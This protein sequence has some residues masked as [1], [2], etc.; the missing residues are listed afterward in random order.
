MYLNK[1]PVKL[2]KKFKPVNSSHIS[3]KRI[4][5][6]LLPV[7]LAV[8]IFSLTVGKEIYG[9]RELTLLSFAILNFSGYLFF[10]LMPVEVAFIYFLH[11][12]L[13]IYLLNLV[14]ISTAIGSQLIDY[15]IGR[16]LSKRFIDRLIGRHRFD[17]AEAEIRR[18]GNITIFIFNL[19]PL[20]SPV[21]LL[22]AGMLK[23][24]LPQ[25]L[26]YSLSGLL[27]KYL[28]ITIIFGG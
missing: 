23:Q 18:Y 28:L 24:R 5:L 15:L 11:S 26:F 1:K 4:I 13:N 9:N 17:R 7:V 16:S 8:I 20:S 6:F 27:V 10:L 2:P 14:A 19:L 3:I 21:I 22:A 12:D 25:V